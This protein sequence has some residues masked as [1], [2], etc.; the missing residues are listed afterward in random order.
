M[1][2]SG[3]PCMNCKEM[4]P[5]N[6]GEFFAEVFVCPGCYLIAKRYY[7]RGQQDV[8]FVLTMM[9]E[10][11]RLGLMRG[12]LQFRT[13]REIEGADKPELLERLATLAQ[14]T[15]EQPCPSGQSTPPPALSEG[16]AGPS[17]SSKPNPAG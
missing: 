10:A 5:S 6:E 17:S 9:K 2:E 12:E 1:G 14:R 4:V 7:E 8:K 16:A 3:L 15:K 11:I 13:V